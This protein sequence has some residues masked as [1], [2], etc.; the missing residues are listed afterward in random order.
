VWCGGD[1]YT[2]FSFVL[3]PPDF[4]DAGVKT[5]LKQNLIP[6]YM[7]VGVCVGDDLESE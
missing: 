7:C 5:K 4:Y 3:S 2:C 6:L 1:H